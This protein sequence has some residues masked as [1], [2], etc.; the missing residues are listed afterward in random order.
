MDEVQAHF[1]KGRAY[2]GEFNKD[3]DISQ[4]TKRSGLNFYRF[5]LIG[6]ILQ[7]LGFACKVH[8]VEK[9]KHGVVYL[10][11]KSFISWKERHKV[12]AGL[13]VQ[14]LNQAVLNKDFVKA[15]KLICENFAK[16][17]GVDSKVDDGKV[18]LNHEFVMAKAEEQFESHQFKTEILEKIKN[19]LESHK[20]FGSITLGGRAIIFDSE[21]MQQKHKDLNEGL[22][23]FFGRKDLFK[24]VKIYVEGGCILSHEKFKSQVMER[25]E[26]FAKEATLPPDQNAEKAQAQLLNYIRG[27]VYKQEFVSD[28]KSFINKW[29]QQDEQLRFPGDRA[30]EF[31]EQTIDLS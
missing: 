3:N 6:N 15:I 18:T 31:F 13:D 20:E 10:K 16:N 19:K 30:R 27:I 25:A 4:D 26:K 28:P 29:K 14:S 7:K 2:F 5:N 11:S 12:D 23:A 1:L 9:E 22:D 17:K 24:G 8:Y 21:E